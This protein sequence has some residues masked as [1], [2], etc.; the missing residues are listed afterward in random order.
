MRAR[1][2]INRLGAAKNGKNVFRLNCGLK[3]KKI[4]VRC[5]DLPT[6]RRRVRAEHGGESTAVKKTLPRNGLNFRF[7]L[8]RLEKFFFDLEHGSM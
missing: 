3:K 6:I 8:L 7:D 4:N 2:K 1:I 5:F